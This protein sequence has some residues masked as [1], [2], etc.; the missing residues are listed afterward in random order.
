MSKVLAIVRSRAFRAPSLRRRGRLVEDAMLVVVDALALR[1]EVSDELDIMIEPPE[2][3]GGEKHVAGAGGAE[4]FEL[5]DR[6]GAVGRIMSGVAAVGGLWKVPGAAGGAELENRSVALAHDDD[7]RVGGQQRADSFQNSLHL[8]VVR[9]LRRRPLAGAK[10][11]TLFREAIVIG[12]DA[13]ALAEQRGDGAKV[14]IA[15]EVL[16][17]PLAAARGFRPVL[18]DEAHPSG[19]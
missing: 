5:P 11:L 15:L 7:R 18:V 14:V 10:V 8:R 13:Q 1:A 9:G 16:P 3:R 17:P 2:V 12:I 4:L 6:R 19:G